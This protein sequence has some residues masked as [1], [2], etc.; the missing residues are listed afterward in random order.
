MRVGLS[1]GGLIRGLKKTLVKRVGLCASGFDQTIK[2]IIISSQISTIN[3]F[4]SLIMTT[5]HRRKNVRRIQILMNRY[6]YPKWAY[7]RD[8]KNVSEKGGLIRTSGLI[9]SAGGLICRV[10]RYD[11][12]LHGWYRWVVLHLLV[13][14]VC[15]QI[16]G[17][18]ARNEW[19]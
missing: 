17:G 16:T 2:N 5:M 19:C 18:K 9:I 11:S 8:R 1:V 15:G 14:L 13:A 12:N 4:I 10:L 3:S 7:P 6:R